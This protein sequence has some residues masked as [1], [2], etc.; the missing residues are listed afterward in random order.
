MAADGPPRVRGRGSTHAIALRDHEFQERKVSHRERSNSRP[1]DVPR[2]AERGAESH[3]SRHCDDESSNARGWSRDERSRAS[4]DSRSRESRSPMGRA[5]SFSWRREGAS[6]RKSRSPQWH[7]DMYEGPR[8]GARGTGGVREC[9]RRVAD[10]EDS[11]HFDPYA[12]VRRSR[13]YDPDPV[14]GPRAPPE[15]AVGTE[16]R[17]IIGDG[18]VPIGYDRHRRS[19][20]PRPSHDAYEWK[21][22]AG[23]VAIF[24]KKG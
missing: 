3:Y 8:D 13:A 23:G 5:R 20:S 21:S 15:S 10:K 2:R 18:D 7:H 4:Y 12:V 14:P 17:R 22:L 11:A 16:G 6:Q 19:S 24:V 9:D 1:R